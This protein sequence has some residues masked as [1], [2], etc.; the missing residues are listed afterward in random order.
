MNAV[1][2]RFL[3]TVRAACYII[4]VPFIVAGF[5]A[6]GRGFRFGNV[7]RRAD[8]A[9][10]RFGGFMLS[11]R[12]EFRA[13]VPV[14][15]GKYID[16]M[17]ISIVLK[18]EFAAAGKRILRIAASSCY[19]IFADG[20]LFEMGPARAGHEYFRVDEMVWMVSLSSPR[21]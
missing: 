3:L 9:V 21:K 12:V 16:E 18:A 5:R 20:D 1:F 8:A 7:R 17:N 13:A 11:K 15:P 19:Q 6:G 4:N 10:R 14:W 2:E